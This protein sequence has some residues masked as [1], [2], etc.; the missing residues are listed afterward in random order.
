MG[1]DGAA[2]QMLWDH[3]EAHPDDAEAWSSA[4]IAAVRAG[5]GD[6]VER[7]A[8]RLDDL[9]PAYAAWVRGRWA[10]ERGDHGEAAALAAQGLEADAGAT[11][12][13]RLW[14]YAAIELGDWAAV[15]ERVDELLPE[16]GEDDAEPL[17]W[18]RMLASTPLGDW[19]AVRESAARV[20]MEL[21]EGEGPVDADIAPV[22]LAF[23]PRDDVAGVRTGPVTA[24]VVGIAREGEQRAGARVLFDPSPLEEPGDERPLKFPVREVLEPSAVDAYPFDA[25]DPGDDAWVAFRDRLTGEG[26]LVNSYVYPED[27]APGGDRIGLYGMLA[28]PQ[29]TGA[30]AAHARLGELAQALPE[31]FFWPV[32]AE[33]AGDAEAAERQRAAAT[34]LGL[35]PD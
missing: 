10:V 18:T 32:L 3:A 14:L 9:R 34:E 1:R 15:R 30:E 35:L 24:R 23:G 21:P 4:G 29:A 12:L 8:A 6:A 13:R 19:A 17:H 33:A 2:Q 5:D 22:T 26:W 31:P 27:H 11:G 28:V 20:G 25:I 7:A 16:A